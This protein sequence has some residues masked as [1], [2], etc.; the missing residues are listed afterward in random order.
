MLA[1]TSKT[2]LSSTG[3]EELFNEPKTEKSKD[4]SNEVEP[5]SVSKDSDAPIIEDWVSDDEEEEGN[6]QE[7]LQDKGVVD[8][9]CSRHMTGNMSF[10]TDYEKFDGDILPLEES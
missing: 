9:G 5:A 6:P 10:L 2:D 7:H 4:K 1:P 3:L 8:S